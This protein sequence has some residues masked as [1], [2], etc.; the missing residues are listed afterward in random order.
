MIRDINKYMRRF[1]SAVP[2]LNVP[3]NELIML[4]N[5][6]GKEYACFTEIGCQCVEDMLELE[7]IQIEHTYTGKALGGGLDWLKRNGKTDANILFWNTYNSRDLS[8][9]IIDIKYDSLPKQ[10]HKYFTES[11]QE[12]TWKRG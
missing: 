8:E 6:L 5:Y 10:F 1:D 9:K 4:E 12:E 7:G 11:V 2:L 3:E